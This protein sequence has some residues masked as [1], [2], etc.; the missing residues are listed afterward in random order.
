MT[1]CVQYPDNYM[2]CFRSFSDELDACVS[3]HGGMRWRTIFWHTW[4]CNS[5]SLIRMLNVKREPLYTFNWHNK[6]LLMPVSH[7]SVVWNGPHNP[8]REK[9]ISKWTTRVRSIT[10]MTCLIHIKKQH[11]TKIKR[12]LD[13]WFAQFVQTELRGFVGRVPLCCCLCRNSSTELCFLQ[14]QIAWAFSLGIS[15]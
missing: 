15:V 9:S 4:I 2:R 11:T 7:V 6:C 14:S 10:R 3:G 5:L 8:A 13:S 1:K 12:Y